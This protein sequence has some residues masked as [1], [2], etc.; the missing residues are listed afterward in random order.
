LSLES[1]KR[2]YMGLH[3]NVWAETLCGPANHPEPGAVGRIQN[4]RWSPARLGRRTP[5]HGGLYILLR[6]EE[7]DI[8]PENG[9]SGACK[10]NQ[11][12]SGTPGHSQRCSVDLKALSGFVEINL[13]FHPMK[14]LS[15]VLRKRPV[16]PSCPAALRIRPADLNCTSLPG[17]IPGH[18]SQQTTA[19]P[20]IHCIRCSTP[21]G[22][23]SR[24]GPLLV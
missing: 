11:A 19:S 17:G 16:A 23:T 5:I 1:R 6:S 21:F 20:T 10:C 15:S 24:Y 9:E 18:L 3:I 14:R 2:A 22:S 7:G 4:R 12:D 13:P 8:T